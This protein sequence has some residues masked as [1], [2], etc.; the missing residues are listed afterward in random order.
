MFKTVC[1]TTQSIEKTRQ[2]QLV[3]RGKLEQNTAIGYKSMF[4]MQR[5]RMWKS[6]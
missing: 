3:K 5:I 6:L 4:S 2:K 1:K